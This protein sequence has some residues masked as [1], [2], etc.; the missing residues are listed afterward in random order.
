MRKGS[1]VVMQIHYHPSGKPEVDQSTVGI[2]YVKKGTPRPVVAIMIIDRTLYIP[3][4]TEQHAMAGSYTLPMDVTLV[5]IIPHM[6]LLGREMKASATLPDGTVDPQ[7]WIKDWNFN[8]QDQYVFD[9]PK[10]L[11]KG[12]RLDLSA[13]Y[14]NTDK[15]PVNPNTPPKLVTW[16][17]QTTDEMFICFYLVTTDQPDQLLPLIVDNFRALGPKLRAKPSQPAAPPSTP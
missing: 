5:G 9:Q 6:H 2:H 3:A 11:P 14:D 1:D 12:T 13:T 17:E 16:G 7:I 15:N 8:W 10:R 4:G